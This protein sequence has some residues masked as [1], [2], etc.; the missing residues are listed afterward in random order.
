LDTS[1]EDVVERV[2]EVTGGEMVKYAVD[3][4]GGPTASQIVKCLGMQARLLVYG[5]L[6]WTAAEFTNRQL[7]GTGAS[8]A[9]FALQQYSARQSKFQMLQLLK[10]IGRLM[11]QNVLTTDIAEVYPVEKYLDALAAAESPG[12]Q[13]KILLQFAQR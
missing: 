11:Q 9:G 13:G 10:Q 3:A 5:S 7:I 1:R 2:R 8:I 4:V 6:D 12:R